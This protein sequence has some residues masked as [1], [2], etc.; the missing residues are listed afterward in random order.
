MQEQNKEQEKLARDWDKRADE[1]VTAFRDKSLP[2]TSGSLS[3]AQDKNKIY[4][5][6]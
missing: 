4:W 5:K 1:V 2:E 6:G 3:G